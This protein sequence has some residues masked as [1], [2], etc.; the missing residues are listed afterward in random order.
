MIKLNRPACPRPAA[1]K[2]GN[3]KHPDNKAALCSSIHG[4]CMYCESRITHV[5]FGH[6]EHIKPKAANLFPQLE[7]EWTNLGYVCDRCNNAK[8]NKYFPGAEL[9]NPY[10]DD[11]AT[12]LFAYGSLL[13]A[14][15]GSERGELTINEIQLNRSDLIERRTHHI[16]Q[17]QKAF[18]AARRVG[19]PA[20]RLSALNELRKEAGSDKEFSFV[21]KAFLD[22]LN[23]P[24]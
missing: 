13:F 16:K 6:V 23:V 21:A 1:L 24:A 3:Y 17:L 22:Y 19:N 11:P 20:V 10:E 15:D 7:F 12:H 2:S 4:K 14:E 18:L 9:L 5:N 8:G